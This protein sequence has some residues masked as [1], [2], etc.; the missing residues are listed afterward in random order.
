M[1]VFRYQAI[2]TSG[3]TVAGTIEAADRKAALRLLGQRGLFPSTLEACVP[4]QKAGAAPP[5]GAGRKS[6]TQLSFG[7]GVRRKEITGFTRE[8]S[9]LLGAGI[10]IPQALEGLGEQEENVVL[11]ETIRGISDSV[12]TGAALSTAMDGHPKLFSKLYVSMV[13]VGEEGG[14]L[15]KVMADLADLLEHQDEVR[16]E[17][18]AAVSYPVFV[19]CFGALTVT[20][21]LAFVLPRLF[22]QME[23]ILTTL[24]LPTL[25]LLKVSGFLHHDWFYLVAALAALAAGFRWYVR[26]PDGAEAW[27]G[28][29]LRIP[30]IGSLLRAAALSRFART[31]GTLVRSGVSLLPALKIVENTIGNRVLAR[32]IALVAEETRGGDSLAGPLRKLGVFPR[33]VVQMIDVGEETGKLD[34]MLL[35]VAAIEERHMRARTKTLIS[36]LAPLLIILVGSVVGFVVI[37]IL[38]P[39]FRLSHSMH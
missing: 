22:S 19:L 39:I 28:V 34:E 1:N 36:V 3:A 13:R 10:P 38:V 32:Q 37:A 24:P 33:S 9:A 17:V 27:D 16:G 4:G 12:R 30:I 7:Q 18:V 25:I 35:K 15:P 21:L 5:S 29:K 6:D 2:E 11:R 31:L 14:V 26:R 23:E 20:I 8:I